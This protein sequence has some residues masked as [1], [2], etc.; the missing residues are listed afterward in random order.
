MDVGE[1]CDDGNQID[2]DNCRA[3][4]Q[5]NICGDGK[6]DQQ[7]DGAGDPT[8][9]CDE[10]GAAD[11]AT[12]DSDCTLPRCGDMHTN[13]MFTP[14]G[15][16]RG[17]R[18]DDGDNDSGDGCSADCASMETCG[19]SYINDDL[20]TTGAACLTATGSGTN[21]PELCDDGNQIAGDGCSP[22]C[23]SEEDC[24]NGILDAQ[25]NGGSNP[26][27]LCDDGDTDD[28]DECRNNCQSGFGCG[29]G[30]VDND[31]PTG[32][33]FDEECDNGS[34][35]DS[36]ICDG[37]CT[38]PVCGDNRPNTAAGE[39]C[40]PGSIGVNVA[41]CNSDCTMPACGDGKVNRAFTPV[42]A[43]GPEQCDDNN[44]TA[45]DGCSATC[46]I[47]TCG[48][49]VTESINGEQCDDGN[50]MDLDACRNTASSRAAA[51]ASPAPARPVTPTATARPAT[52]IARS[53]LAATARSTARSRRRAPPVP[54][55][56]TT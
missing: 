12:C 2:E 45:G 20:P 56:A 1:A 40:D 3:D 13:P 47:E 19:D 24:R 5:L 43:T 22:N 9:E 15:A 28:T 14:V 18:C 30:F 55:S 35:T 41:S 44:T 49:G 38:I 52:S 6:R 33:Q 7:S 26:P 16:P 8:E 29:N 21:C 46:Q 48:N 4:C 50:L 34:T 27:E 53:R 31:G 37:D 25:G 10:V 36:D 51:M 11:S 17:E 39:I 32:T 54:S 23:L 42:G